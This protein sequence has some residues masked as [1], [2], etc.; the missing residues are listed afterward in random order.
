[1]SIKNYSNEMGPKMSIFQLLNVV[2]Y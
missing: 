1:M 2:F